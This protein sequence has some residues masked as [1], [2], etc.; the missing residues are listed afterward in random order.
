MQTILTMRHGSH[1]YG[2]ATPRSDIDVKQVFIP[3]AHDIVLGK[4]KPVVT[5][6]QKR[7]VGG[8]TPKNAPG[9]TDVECYSL[10]K[11]IKLFTEGQTVAIDML[12]A[13]PTLQPEQ[14]TSTWSEL[15]SNR[16]KLLSRQCAPFLGY[17]RKQAAKYGIKGSRVAAAR[18]IV[19]ALNQAIGARGL[20][21]KLGTLQEEL[22]Q[23]AAS[24]EHA[25]II[26][27]EIVSQ[28]KTI[29]HLSVCQ[30]K[31]PFTI[32]LKEAHAIYK[33]L[34]DEYGERAVQAEASEGV[35]WKALSHAVRVGTQSL[36][37]L[38]TGF[39]T[40]PRPDAAH[41]LE[42]KLGKL[43]FAQIA[44]EIEGL[45]EE[46]EEVAQS[47]SLPDKPDAAWC[48]EFIFDVYSPQIA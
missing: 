11:F 22:E 44:E 40:F 30:K 7:S 32:T 14:Y 46:V 2:T 31:A 21:E 28:G 4:V 13:T 48:E 41:L 12:F 42:I 6:R 9:D 1:L 35:D 23:F 24:H 16:E 3:S 19:N 39:V 43:P 10:D 36:E 5:L 25:E 37:Y 27:V 47:S 8:F 38:R 15:W 26:E 20:N 34:L 33:R 45:L 18:E 29:K 17:C